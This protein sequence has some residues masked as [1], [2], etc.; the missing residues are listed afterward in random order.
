MATKTKTFALN[1]THT[2][3]IF[4]DMT[5]DGPVIGTLVAIVDRARNLPNRK[6][7]GKQDPYCA[8][9]LGKEAK[10]T[11]TDIRG[12]QTPRW[13]VRSS[14]VNEHPAKPWLTL[15]TRRDQELRFT[16]HDCPDYYQLKVSV[17]TD[18]K[19]TDLI[20]ETWIDLKTIIVPGG[21]Q[22]D[23]WQQLNCK[24]KYA[25]D[26]RLEIT[27]YDSRPKPEKPV[28]K[29]RSQPALADQENG[30]VKQRTPMKRRPLPSDPV[31]GEAPP[32][33]PSDMAPTHSPAPAPVASRSTVS[34]D[35]YQTPPRL[36]GPRPSQ[37]GFVPS[38][39]PL[40]TVE[41]Q[42]P[43]SAHRGR[44][45]DQYS[46]SPQGHN[47]YQTPPRQETSRQPQRQVD[48]YSTS[49]RHPE[50]FDHIPVSSTSPYRQPET[51]GQ[52][53]PEHY[54]LHF[55]E[56]TS[57]PPPAMNDERPPPPP[58]HRNRH[59]SGGQELAHRSSSS[60]DATGSKAPLPVS[61]RHDVL[62]HEAHRHSMAAYSDRPA[63]R[64]Y[65][66]APSGLIAS[67]QYDDQSYEPPLPRH[68]SHD[69]MYDQHHKS[70]Q[71]T[72]EDAPDS[73]GD[74]G[75]Y[76]ES[77]RRRGGSRSYSQEPTYDRDPSPA[78]LNLSRSREVSPLHHTPPPMSS[79]DIYE[80]YGG[81]SSA[82]AHVAPTRYSTSP[83]RDPYFAAS[84]SQPPEYEDGLGSRPHNYSM[85]DLPLSL[86]PGVDPNISQEFS[87]RTRDERNY[88]WRE[89]SHANAPIRGRHLIEGPT[90]SSSWDVE[91]T[92][93]LVHT[94]QYPQYERQPS[95][96]Y[97]VESESRM[98][99]HRSVSPNP[100][101]SSQHTIRRK[102][103]S[104][105]PPPTEQRRLSGVPFS[106]DSFDAYNTGGRDVRSSLDPDAKI[107]TYDGKEIDPSD[108]LPVE[109]WA[110]EPEA[111]HQKQASPEP[112]SRPAPSGAQPM[113]PSGRRQLR[114]AARPQSS[115]PMAHPNYGH[116]EPHTNPA[117]SSTG[118]NRLQKRTD[119]SSG[120]HGFSDSTPL[121]PISSENYQDRTGVYAAN[122]SSRHHQ[123]DYT[124]ENAEPS[125]GYGPP[126]PA[127]VPLPLMSGA[128]GG[129]DE[130]ALEMQRID[131]GA[132]RSR[133]RG[134]Y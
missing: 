54:D 100:P 16:V 3:G 76:T 50:D 43:S 27:F 89:S 128:L 1:G 127:K 79:R 87:E 110:P 55:R 44:H 95:Q 129:S 92:N 28:V 106:P 118:R 32:V 70:M 102:S 26:I 20:G 59:N 24:G 112:R 38:N 122:T 23:Q 96:S 48:P 9:R 104:P 93:A 45:Q 121:G 15:V 84:Q 101:T 105:A 60:F 37:G 25:G 125:R 74:T 86:V 94:P 42:T 130:L 78:P 14:P 65:D 124:N 39:S 73:P 29:T 61:M 131:I 108:Y 69:S 133:R 134:G 126:I 123:W 58:A 83:G 31:T 88:D 111:K 13:Y 57:M 98:R 91:P 62:K 40:Q 49:P 30:S 41:Y 119:R 109:S 71:A 90:P 47:H 35:Q 33:S 5:A 11:K 56:E 81:H 63:F 103:V 82:V 22:A 12:G 6:T 46:P 36:H 7:I 80:D 10:K 34:L 66:S 64:G 72:V 52:P 115:Q 75:I 107:I 2:A 117:P 77:H 67:S 116:Q 4:A 17:F 18:D 19:R 113:P 53:R 99:Q 120:A 97:P 114:I 51:R 8:A 68:H 85:P 21:G 132:G